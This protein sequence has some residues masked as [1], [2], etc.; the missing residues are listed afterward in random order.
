MF[1]MWA[2]LVVLFKDNNQPDIIPRVTM[3]T[4]ISFNLKNIN[5]GIDC[6]D[7]IHSIDEPIMIDIVDINIIGVTVVR[8]SYELNNGR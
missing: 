3:V 6:G 4:G 1:N 5:M 2:V 8:V 7:I